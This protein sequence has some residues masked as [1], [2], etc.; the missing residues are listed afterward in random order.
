MIATRN[1]RRADTI[2]YVPAMISKRTQLIYCT[3]SDGMNFSKYFCNKQEKKNKT[4]VHKHRIT[5]YK[6]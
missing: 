6:I 2:I 3:L 4:S 1:F 5:A